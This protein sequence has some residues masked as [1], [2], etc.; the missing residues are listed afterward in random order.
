MNTKPENQTDEPTF[1]EVAADEANADEAIAGTV[2]PEEQGGESTNAAV[3]PGSM[4]EQILA[5][6]A[7]LAEADKRELLNAADMENFRKRTRQ[8]TQEQLRYAALPVMNDVLEAADNLQRAVGSA[9]SDADSGS[10]LEGVKMV[11]QQISSILE[12]HGCQKIETVGQPFDPNCH[13][14]VQ[15][16][17]SDEFPANTVMMEVRTGFK[18]HDRVIRTAQVFVSTGSA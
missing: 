5:L 2:S 18:L 3:E 12:K 15:M 1:D 8:N 6:T 7:K 11:A 14:A 9:E 4:E 16:Q 17:A 13:E 10:L